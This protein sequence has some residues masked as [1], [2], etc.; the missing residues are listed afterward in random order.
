MLRWS[1]V[2]LAAVLAHGGARAQVVPIGP[3]AGTQ[4]EDFESQ[5]LQGSVACVQERVLGDRAALCSLF[6]GGCWIADALSGVAAIAP[7]S[8]VQLFHADTTVDL[9]FDRPIRRFG[10]WFGSDWVAS[11]S[12]FFLDAA[13]QVVA[14]E[15]FQLSPCSSGCAWIWN[16]WDV[17]SGA[18]IRGLRL[19]T[20][21]AT[22]GHFEL[23]DLVLEF[24]DG[25]ASSYCTAKL[26]SLGCTPLI[27]AAGSASVSAGSG[28]VIAAT[29]VRNQNPGTLFYGVSGPA[30]LAFR[31][32]FL[33]LA[34]PRVRTPLQGSGGS[35]VG[36][37]CSGSYAFDF[38]AWIAA[39]VDP[40]LVVGVQVDAQY[41]SRDP[42]YAP[43]LNVGLTAALEFAPGP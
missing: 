35:A 1:C 15:P 18:A 42:G 33:C 26:N 27:S 32:G 23:E 16:G 12:A 2:L 19:D 22:G 20:A 4:V 43:P 5:A 10:G 36:S 41:W 28:F 34:A 31:G 3:F 30:A 24:A 29:G 8:G 14:T 7:R 38:N 21:T 17:G 37:D 13:G 25:F 40:A 11:G 6:G 9:I 39:G